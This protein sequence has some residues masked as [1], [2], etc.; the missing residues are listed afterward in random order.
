MERNLM[1]KEEL[2]NL[3]FND[4][5]KYERVPQTPDRAGFVA[6]VNVRASNK[7]F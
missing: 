2:A 4:E 3:G 7:W 1:A 6:G 5:E